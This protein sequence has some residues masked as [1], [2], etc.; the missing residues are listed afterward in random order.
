M[1][2]T[3]IFIRGGFLTIGWFRPVTSADDFLWT[4]EEKQRS[5]LSFKLVKSL[6]HNV[7]FLVASS[8]KINLPQWNLGEKVTLLSL[9]P[10]KKVHCCKELHWEDLTALSRPGELAVF[11]CEEDN[12][13]RKL[14]CA[15]FTWLMFTDCFYYQ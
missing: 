15:I 2:L 3:I 8:L 11:F 7:V 6:L 10:G 1:L 9:D 5:Y 4:E 12:S 13:K 14:N